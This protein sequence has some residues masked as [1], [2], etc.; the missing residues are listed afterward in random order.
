MIAAAD[1]RRQA[2]AAPAEAGPGTSWLGRLGRAVTETLGAAE[3]PAARGPLAEEL[4]Y[5]VMVDNVSAAAVA[6]IGAHPKQYPGVKIIRRLRRTYP[7]GTLAAHVLG[8]LGAQPR[9]QERNRTDAQELMGLSGVE[10]QYEWLLR[11]RR[12]TA[13]ELSDHSGRLFGASGR[14]SPARAATSC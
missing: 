10:R 4:D 12:G 5:H 2:K 13:V 1:R 9:P 14:Q 3:P 8:Y 11:G 7:A 6:E